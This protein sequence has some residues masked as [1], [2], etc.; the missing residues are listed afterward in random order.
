MNI[1]VKITH[2]QTVQMQR[3][4]WIEVPARVDVVIDDDVTPEKPLVQHSSDNV[5][6]PGDLG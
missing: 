1:G 2:W 5:L 3:G 4:N 6:V